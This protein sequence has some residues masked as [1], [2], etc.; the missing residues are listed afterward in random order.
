[1]GC[2]RISRSV[3]RKLNVTVRCC[4]LRN[5]SMN[6]MQ[7]LK[8]WAGVAGTHLVCL[9]GSKRKGRYA[10]GRRNTPLSS[11]QSE[12]RAVGIRARYSGRGRFRS[13]VESGS[14][15]RGRQPRGTLPSLSEPRSVASR[16][17]ERRLRRASRGACG[18]GGTEG[19]RVGSYRQYRRGLYALCGETAFARAADVLPAAS[20]S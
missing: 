11:R 13:L 16:T 12:K 15:A 9:G 6:S 4:P 18:G 20:K 5:W 2:G 7:R 14:A 3:S 8:K 17:G 1:N 10:D 19:C